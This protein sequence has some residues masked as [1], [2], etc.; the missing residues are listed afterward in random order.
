MKYLTY[1]L[2]ILFVIAALNTA[3]FSTDTCIDCHKEQKFRV[4]NKAL[5][6]YY[7]DW[8]GSDHDEAGVSCGDCH[9]GDATL[10]KKEE[11]HGK[12]ISP[13]KETSMVFYKNIP[14]TC[15]KCHE[16]VYRNFID[17]KHYKVLEKSGRGPVCITCHGNPL[18][19]VYYTSTVLSTCRGCH[20]L[21]TQNNP[22]VID[23][24]DTILHRMNKNRG[25][26]RWTS[27]HLKDVNELEDKNSE[28]LLAE[29]REIFRDVRKSEKKK[30]Q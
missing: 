13:Y 22:E 24:A 11:A 18:A 4:Q 28:K 8:K 25:L 23:V 16:E 7:Q 5:F 19:N 14:G 26:L 29:L 2:F 6:D 1:A 10:A 3:A 20:N 17:S 9:G 30:D 12:D 21:Q 27:L 15:G